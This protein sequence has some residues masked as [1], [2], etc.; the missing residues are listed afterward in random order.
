MVVWGP[1]F[2]GLS[3]C[4]LGPRQKPGDPSSEVLV[5]VRCQKRIVELSCLLGREVL[6]DWWGVHGPNVS[7]VPSD[8]GSAQ[9]SSG[10]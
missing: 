10:G 7:L 3:W 9:G 5:G 8:V 4:V 2:R 6:T 1:L